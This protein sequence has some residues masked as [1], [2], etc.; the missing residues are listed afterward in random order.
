MYAIHSEMK[1]MGN[2]GSESNMGSGVHRGQRCIGAGVNRG[3]TSRYKLLP[4]GCMIAGYHINT[5]E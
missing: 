1:S 5:F 4:H 2:V 3:H